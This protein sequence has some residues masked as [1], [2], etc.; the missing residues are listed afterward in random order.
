MAC[1]RPPDPPAGTNLRLTGWFGETIPFDGEARYVCE[2]GMQFEEDPA[3]EDVIYTCQVA[4]E[5]CNSSFLL[6][7]VYRN[8][9]SS[10][11]VYI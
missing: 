7:H 11:S 1:L 10:T 6:G 5:C 3:Q 8:C 9:T 2:R 4:I